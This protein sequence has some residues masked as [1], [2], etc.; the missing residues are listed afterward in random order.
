MAAIYSNGGNRWNILGF[1][2]TKRDALSSLYKISM[3]ALKRDRKKFTRY[4]NNAHHWF[5]ILLRQLWLV[6]KAHLYT[7]FLYLAYAPQGAHPGSYWSYVLELSMK[8]IAQCWSLRFA[9]CVRDNQANARVIRHTLINRNCF[10]V[11]IH[12]KYRLT[13]VYDLSYRVNKI[14]DH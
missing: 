10:S 2:F 5:V 6:V 8:Y 4:T 1:N 9:G 13:I 3:D 7:Q 12:Q 14:L 11:F